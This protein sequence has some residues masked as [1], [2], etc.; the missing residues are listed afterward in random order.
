MQAQKCVTCLYAIND[1][2]PDSVASFAHGRMYLSSLAWAGLRQGGG[3]AWY[4]AYR[5]YAR[6][7]HL[8]KFWPFLVAKVLAGGKGQ[9]MAQER[10]FS[11]TTTNSFTRMLRRGT[12]L[13]STA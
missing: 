3:K 1:Y 11:E 12:M 6:P 2:D 5:G 9:A 8:I 10:K 13:N 4:T 7:A